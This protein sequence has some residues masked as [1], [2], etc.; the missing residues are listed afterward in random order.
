MTHFIA[1]DEPIIFAE[2]M[3][4]RDHFAGLALQGMLANSQQQEYFDDNIAHLAYSLANS[5]MKVRNNG[6]T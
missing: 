2:E 5:M 4:L 1:G 6:T 3:E